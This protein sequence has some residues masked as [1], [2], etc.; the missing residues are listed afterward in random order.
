VTE[1]LNNTVLGVNWLQ[2]ETPSVDRVKEYS[3]M[4]VEADWRKEETKPSPSW[5]QAGE[6]K[7]DDL[8]VRYRE[9]MD[10][11]LKS[12]NVSIA[13]GEKVGIVGRTGAGKSSL[14]LALF[15]LIEP[16]RGHVTIDD[17]NTRELGLHDLR[18]RL[19]ILPQD[20]VIFAGSVRM[21]LDPFS[22]YTDQQLWEAVRHAHLTG[23]VDGLQDGL[24]HDCGEGGENLSVGQ[25]QLLCLAR[26]LL[27]KTH[28][29]VLDEATA[30]VD[31]ETDELIQRTIRSEFS[32]CTVLTIAHRLNT[33]IDYDKILVL[34]KGEVNEFDTPVRL[35]QDPSSVF[36]GMAKSAGLLSKLPELIAKKISSDTNTVHS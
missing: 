24:G 30:A 4:E 31:M 29:L 6:V 17:V 10:L 35:M 28:V 26:T 14:T 8:A 12:I 5:P 13:P 18:S 34:D 32:E 15:R 36:H 21:N 19:T 3:E 16:A 33:V 25:R 22:R 20:P 2:T 11:V 23:F 27:H 7:V 9:G 1:T